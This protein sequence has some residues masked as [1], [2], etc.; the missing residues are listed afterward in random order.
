MDANRRHLHLVD[1]HFQSRYL[2]VVVMSVVIMLNLI[3]GLG[4]F[5]VEPL[6]GRQLTVLHAALLGLAELILVVIAYYVGMRASQRVAGPVYAMVHAIERLAD[7]DFRGQLHLRHDDYFKA[8]G[9][10]LNGSLERLRERI[11][12]LQRSADELAAT[13]PDDGPSRE[14]AERLRGQLAA[15]RTE[16]KADDETA[17]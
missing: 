8:F 15:F 3:I 13:L 6:F 7:G 9:E 10:E 4:F 12:E 17:G 5:F 1:R 11:A 2:A 16:V 14:V